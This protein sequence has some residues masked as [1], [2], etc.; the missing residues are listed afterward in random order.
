MLA[1]QQNIDAA[2]ATVGSRKANY[3]PQ[4]YAV[5][6]IDFLAPADMGKSAGLT[7]GI[8]AG[9]PILDGGRRK[10]EVDEAQQAVE[11]ARAN[12][13]VIELQVRA[14]IAGAEALVI[15]ARQNIRHRDIPDNI[16]G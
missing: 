12:R 10:A 3:K 5:G 13:D 16:G 6:M 15:A 14:D 9:I 7:V 11:Q 2:L 4:V 1:A 8:V